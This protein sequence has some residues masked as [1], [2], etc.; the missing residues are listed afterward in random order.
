MTVE[1]PALD[2]YPVT[3]LI[4]VHLPFKDT[5]LI[6]PYKIW[7]NDTLLVIN[8]KPLEDNRFL[9]YY[10]LNSLEPLN[11]YGNIGR[12]PG[13]YLTPDIYWKSPESFLIT[14]KLKY[15]IFYTD[16]LFH[17]QF[18]KPQKI[19][20]G[21]GL[22]AANNAYLLHD[23]LIFANSTMSDYQFSIANIHTNEY[24]I[25]YKNYPEVIKG[26]EMTDFIANSNIYRAM[27]ILKPDTM[28]SVA[29]VYNLFPIIDFVSLKDLSSIRLKFP[30]DNAVNKITISDKLNASV[31]NRTEY[32][33][34]YYSTNKYIY[35]LYNDSPI[36]KLYDNQNNFE[37]HQFSWQG[38][39]T[40]RY[41]L[42]CY[43]KCFCVNEKSKKI[44]GISFREDADYTSEIIS[45]TLS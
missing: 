42:N 30:I 38:K 12:G 24:L 27:Y 11:S 22:T 3:N 36:E 9:K 31:Q 4:P 37:I 33:T 29:I 34:S 6:A 1:L 15:T 39:L 7:V 17:N 5:T 23:S 21:L 32:Y 28:D 26:S 45:F 2:S 14:E 43:L 40:K 25:N 18:Y 10:A 16:S 35:L 19:N 44:Y 8:D 41:K 13:E 20:V